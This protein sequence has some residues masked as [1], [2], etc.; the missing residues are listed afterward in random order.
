MIM[1]ARRAKGDGKRPRRATK[2]LVVDVGGTN[3]KILVTG[4][5]EPRKIPSGP[6]MTASGM[7]A[8]VHRLAA[9]WS[10]DVI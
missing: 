2:V 6:R 8:A 1:E 9:D 4:K 10:Y 5:R 7:V 3:V